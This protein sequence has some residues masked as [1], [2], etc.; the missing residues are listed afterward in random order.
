MNFDQEAVGAYGSC[1]EGQRKNFVALA[2][3]VA[4]IDEDGKMAAFFYGGN[5]GEVEG[6]ARKVGEGADAAFTEH[7]VVVAFAEDVLG[8][9][10]EFIKGGAHAA[11]EEHRLFSA[12]GAFEKRKVL[13]VA[14]ADLND[15]GP[16]VDEVQAFV[17]DGFG[18]DAEAVGVANFG[19]NF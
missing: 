6:V 19:E 4:G 14:G 18:D 3:A 17:I 15:V 9:H 5:D 16:L 2:G 10:Q 13:H 1:G 11:L 8:G 7:D 12:S